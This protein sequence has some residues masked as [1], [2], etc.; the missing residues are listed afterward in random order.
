MRLLG[1]LT[2]VSAAL[3]H[4]GDEQNNPQL[5]LHAVYLNLSE[6]AVVIALTIKD[7]LRY[8]GRKKLS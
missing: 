6:E 3:G 8:K 4:S 2:R 5:P 7:F 1:R